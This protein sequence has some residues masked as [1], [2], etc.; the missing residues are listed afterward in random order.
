MFIG[1]IAAMAHG[2][3]QPLFVVIFGNVIDK[4]AD[5]KQYCDLQSML[6]GDNETVSAIFS[7]SM[8]LLNMTCTDILTKNQTT[9]YGEA[10]DIYWNASPADQLVLEEFQSMSQGTDFYNNTYSVCY[11]AYKSQEEFMDVM[12][13]QIIY[14]VIIGAAS[15]VAGYMQYASWG[16]AAENQVK[17]IRVSF[18]KNLIRQDV[19]WYDQQESGAVTSKFAEDILLIHKGIGD[20]LALLFQSI[21]AFLAGMVVAFVK[22]WE[23]ALVVLSLSPLLAA[24]AVLMMKFAFT[25]AQDETKAYAKAGAIAQEVLGN[26]RTVTSFGGQNVEVERYAVNLE[27]ARRF[28]TKKGVVLGIMMG[29][30]FF[31]IFGSY[32]LGF[33][34]GIKLINDGVAGY[35]IGVVT[36]TFFAVIMGTFS[37]G[38]SVTSI[39]NFAAAR[40]AAYNVFQIIDRKPPIDS[41]TQSGRKIPEEKLQCRVDF[42]NI[43]FSYPNRPDVP[44]LKNVN[45]SV[46]PGSTVALVG[47][48]GCGKS[49]LV[50]LLQRFYDP[51][52][53]R[54]V[55]DG[56]DLRDMN[57]FWW[58][59]RIGVVSQEPVLFGASIFENIRYG[60]PLATK[61]DV[62]NA[63][64]EANAHGFVSQL[65]NGYDTLV[66]E[67]GT[68]LSGGQ[69]QRIAIAR[70]LVRGPRLLLLDEATSALDTES[71][72]IVQQALDKARLGRTT[73]VVAHRLSTIQTADLIVVI[74]SGKI[75][76]QG[77]HDELLKKEGVYFKLVE[78]QQG[79]DNDDIELEFATAKERREALANKGRTRT[80]STTKDP[81]AG[82][83]SEF[84]PNGETNILNA[85]EKKKMEEELVKQHFSAKRIWAMATDELPLIILGSVA[86]LVCGGVW[87]AFSIIFSQMMDAFT[88]CDPQER[89][90]KGLMYSLIFLAIGGA[91][92]IGFTVMM[93]CFAMAGERLV[94]KIRK[95]AFQAMLRQE[96][97]WFDDDDNSTGALTSRLATK[98][99]QVRDAT[100]SQLAQ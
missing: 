29:A 26:I 17:A 96:I 27:E 77:T 20:K 18:F 75:V 65:P 73:I 16:M 45:L 100:G 88:A 10:M 74:D 24:A 3:L 52:G 94:A 63:A 57:T 48:S 54:V 9:L 64:R 28:G 34:Y 55:V 50:Q 31:I 98:C 79:K 8:E 12:T 5:P 81:E 70:A 38:M 7:R 87:P 47:S 41:F 25:Q 6:N 95:L 44:I 51:V 80:M 85:A 2:A 83:K 99:G 67:Q 89:Y 37:L 30:V 42:Q 53:G 13:E 78:A 32:S 40:S 43:E 61:K 76:E 60:C 14:F 62:E 58:R 49:T 22:G 11:D 92:F 90:E 23:L 82:R 72:A 66:G 35:S 39:Q 84:Q 86:A 59:S 71:E 36:T 21:A 97:A 4:F 1:T 91:T 69:K 56:V 15:W 19:G 68:Q 33:S 93:S 46:E